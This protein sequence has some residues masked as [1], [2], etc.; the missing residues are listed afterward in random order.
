MVSFWMFSQKQQQQPLQLKHKFKAIPQEFELKT[1]HHVWSIE[2][3]LARLCSRL[4][5]YYHHVC[6]SNIVI[7]ICTVFGTWWVLNNYGIVVNIYSYLKFL[8]TKENSIN[9]SS[10]EKHHS[11]YTFLDLKCH[12]LF[13][14][15]VNWC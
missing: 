15:T 3:L 7:S 10:P 11:H 13:V 1:S 6:I 14:S 2:Y 9:M 12:F 5:L 8:V 4:W